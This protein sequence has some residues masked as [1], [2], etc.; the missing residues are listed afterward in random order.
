MNANQWS[1]LRH[2]L[3]CAAAAMLASTLVLSSVLWLFTKP[4][5]PTTNSVYI[6]KPDR[7]EGLA[8]SHRI[9]AGRIR[10]QLVKKTS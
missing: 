9:D 7:S 8:A 1:H 6:S 10:D 3:P 5:A 4:S 2:R